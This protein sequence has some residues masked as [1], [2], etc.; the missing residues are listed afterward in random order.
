MTSK[1]HSRPMEQTSVGDF[2]PSW[3][4][5][6]KAESRWPMFAAVVAIIAGQTWVASSLSLRPVWLFPAIAGVLLLAS[7]AVYL[8]SQRMPSRAARVLSISLVVVLV[9]GN[10]ISLFLLVRGIFVGS[11]LGA[12]DLLLTGAALWVVNVLVFTLSYWE[13]DGDGPEARAAGRQDYPDL[14]FPQQQQDQQG[15]APADWKPTFADYLYVSLTSATAFSPT[16]AMPYT[17][18]AK[19]AMGVQSLLSFAIAAVLV[20]RAVNV[21]KG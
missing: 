4:R 2:V 11:K 1:P 13:L 19:L 5:P 17:K 3:Q 21:A 20:A 7:V 18:R 8:P 10:I 14:V 6:T 16:D 9:I 15:L 12:A